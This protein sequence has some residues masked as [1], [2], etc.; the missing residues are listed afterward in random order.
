[1]GNKQSNVNFVH[2]IDPKTKRKAYELE[3]QVLANGGLKLD[4]EVYVDDVY[5]EHF[6]NNFMHTIRCGRPEQKIGKNIIFIH[7]YQG[8]SITFYKLFKHFYPEYNVFCPDIIGMSL[9]SRPSIKFKSTEDCLNFFIGAIEKWREAL[10]IERFYLVGHSLGGYFSALYALKYPQ[11]I[12]K[13]TLLSPAGI[14]DTTKGGSVHE[15]MPTGKKIGFKMLGMFWGL[16]PTMQGAFSNPISKVFMKAPLR[17][18]YKLSEE[19]N[20]LM[21]QMTELSYQYPPDLDHAIY[22]IFK[23]PIPRVHQPLEDKLFGE[24]KDFEVD[25]YFGEED[26]M[27]QIGSIRLCSKDPKRFKLFYVKNGHNFNLDSADELGPLILHNYKVKEEIIIE[28]L[29]TKEELN[30]NVNK[31]NEVVS[32]G[33]HEKESF[34]SQEEVKVTSK[35]E[36]ED[37]V[38][39]YK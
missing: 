28:K 22:H 16:K 12:E 13:L 10:G 11:R 32:Q 29:Q 25:I 35:I 30:E 9:S 34:S 14:T 15:R 17:K 8:S 37:D 31:E 20:E 33:D 39:M 26:W 38:H 6:G 27:D 23:H 19:E 7:G 4:E 5:F 2:E 24:V 21:A 36:V 3:R 18:R 1:M